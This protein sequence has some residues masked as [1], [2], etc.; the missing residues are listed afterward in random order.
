MEQ[1]EFTSGK[2]RKDFASILG[3]HF[4]IVPKIPLMDGID[5]T[6]ASLATCCIDEK[7]CAG[8]IDALY[9]YRREFDDKSKMFK[10]KPLHDHAS[11][12]ADAMRYLAVG[13]Q[14]AGG[15]N[16]WGVKKSENYR[17]KH[18]VKTALKRR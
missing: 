8:L 1:R 16:G 17:M 12:Y 5:A 10:D 14:N 13:W 4:D 9:S 18:K 7:K 6:R 2:T 15:S 11:H 3:F